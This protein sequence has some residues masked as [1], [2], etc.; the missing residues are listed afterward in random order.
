M[1]HEVSMIHEEIAECLGEWESFIPKPHH[2]DLVEVW[3]NEMKQHLADLN[4][5]QDELAESIAVGLIEAYDAWTKPGNNF[6]LPVDHESTFALM[7]RPQTAQRTTDWYKEFQTR[8]TASEIF[9]I[10]G[11]GRERAILAMQKAGKL[12]MPPRGNA[13]VVLKEKMSPLDWGICFEPVVK[14]ILEVEWGAMIHECGRFVHPVDTRLA[15]S[16][17]G[18]LLKVKVKPQMAGHLLEIKCPKSRKIGKKIPMEYFY[19]MQLQMEVAG[20]RACEYVEARIEMADIVAGKPHTS[21][22]WCGLIAVVGCFCDDIG[23]WKPCR[24]IYGPVGD[25]AWKPDLGLNEQTMETNMWVCPAFHHETV[26]RDEIWFA[27]LKPKIDEFWSDVEKAKQGLFTVPESTRKKKE[28][29]CE[30]VDS[31]PEAEV[32]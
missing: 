30:I 31:E 12:D 5:D 2:S 25:L 19:Q 17:D 15:A 18:L 4:A 1:T 22:G 3:K 7:Q 6:D 14:Q 9:K 23:A 8:L 27:S 10:F 26:L 16:P 29:V 21:T 24:Y 28:V 13:L 32:V 11:S 20:V